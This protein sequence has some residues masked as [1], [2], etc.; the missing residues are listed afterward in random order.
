[1]TRRSQFSAIEVVL[2]MMLFA[3]SSIYYVNSVS[4][5]QKDYKYNIDTGLDSLYYNESYRFLIMNENLDVSHKVLDWSSLNQ[6]LSNMYNNFELTIGNKT[7]SKFI[8]NCNQD[9]NN[10]YSTERIISI[11]DASTYEFRRVKLGVCY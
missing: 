6:T 5:S 7:T 1:M 9:Y 10:K 2:V 11:G 8:Y 3:F 4:T